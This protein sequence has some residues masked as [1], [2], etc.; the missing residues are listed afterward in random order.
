MKDATA[1]EE[2]LVRKRTEDRIA[3]LERIAAKE[4]EIA[5]ETAEL[6]LAIAQATA[7]EIRKIRKELA[8]SLAAPREAVE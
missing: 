6:R 1:S 2:E 4:I 7:A 5:G 8:A 3:D